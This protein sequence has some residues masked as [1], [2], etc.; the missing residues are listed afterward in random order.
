MDIATPYVCDAL[1]VRQDAA[2][3][4]ERLRPRFVL[5]TTAGLHVVRDRDGLVCVPAQTRAVKPRRRAA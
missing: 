3:V 1:P 2:E 5:A 4:L